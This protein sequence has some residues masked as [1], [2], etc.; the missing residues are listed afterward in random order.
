MKIELKHLAPYLPYKL[1]GVSKEG[2]TFYLATGNNMLGRGVEDRDIGTWLSTGIKP[3]LRP[4]SDLTKELYYEL[5]GKTEKDSFGFWYGKHNGGSDKRDYIYHSG[6]S[7]RQYF[8]CDGYGQ[9]T[10]KMME[11]FL[12]HHFDIFGLI[13]EGLAIDINTIK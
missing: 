3:I 10:Y 8:L 5:S 11:F 7:S 6:Y 2:S 4:L 12:E 9:F 1:T 13:P